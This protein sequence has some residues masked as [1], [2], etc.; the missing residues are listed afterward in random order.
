MRLY[1][2]GANKIVLITKFIA[3]C[4]YPCKNMRIFLSE[5]VEK[6]RLLYREKILTQGVFREKAIRNDTEHCGQGKLSDTLKVSDSYAYN[7]FCQYT[8][9]L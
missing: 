8:Y 4:Y 7:L 9:L 3:Q 5:S 2:D 6:F 1:R